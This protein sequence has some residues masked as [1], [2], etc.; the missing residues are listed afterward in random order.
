MNQD[1]TV[2]ASIDIGSNSILLLALDGDLKPILN[3]ARVTGLGRGL[4]STGKFSEEAM[5]DSRAVFKYYHSLCVEKN[6]DPSSVIVT[7]TEASR[8]ASN[9]KDFFAEIKSHFG[10]DVQIITGK[11]EAYYSTL[12]VLADEKIKDEFIT[13][14]DIGGASTELIRVNT[15][16]RE[17]INSFSMPIGVVRLNSWLKD[18][19]REEKRDQVFELYSDQIREVSCS[20]VYCVA[21]TMTSVGNMH[22]GHKEFIESDV[23]GLMI[24]YKE[25]DSLFSRYK[26]VEAASI[27]E[28]FP[29]LGKRASTI[30]S[31]LYLA[32]SLLSLIGC[33]EAY[34]STFGLRYGT[35]LA[36]GIE[37]GFI[38]K[39]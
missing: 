35:I 29:F 25:I 11:A 18:G 5:K 1:N 34:I 33:T 13:I 6:I 4:D 37:D 2:R 7:A 19:V 16:T 10:F 23:H 3:E 14:M 9:S 28:E 20:R 38:F 26:A 31:G 24:K 21:G 30:Q 8:V 36:G 22:L 27:L 12:G 32:T 39:N 17:I 15:I